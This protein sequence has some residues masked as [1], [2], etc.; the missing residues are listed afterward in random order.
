ML[1]PQQT[2]QVTPALYS[3]LKRGA[4]VCRNKIIAND[5]SAGSPTETLLRLLRPLD[6]NTK[7]ISPIRV[8]FYGACTNTKKH[9]KTTKQTKQQTKR[10]KNRNKN[11]ASL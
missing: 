9:K 1:F 8:A 2:V 10:T 3:N 5:P 6:K 4:T 7:H 11:N